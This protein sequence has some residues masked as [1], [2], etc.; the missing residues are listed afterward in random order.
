MSLETR[1]SKEDRQRASEAGFVGGC[2]CHDQHKGVHRFR[3]F[4]KKDFSKK[5]VKQRWANIARR[6][7]MKRV[8]D[9]DY[10]I[11]DRKNHGG[12]DKARIMYEFND[13]YPQHPI[14]TA[15]IKYIIKVQKS[16]QEYNSVYAVVDNLEGELI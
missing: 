13:R 10:T 11:Q 12:I 8:V 2:S 3:R 5:G 6:F 4:E 1:F 7:V 14:T 9:P 16:P 15:V